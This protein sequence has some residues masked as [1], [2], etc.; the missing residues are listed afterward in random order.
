MT[1]L[2]THVEHRLTLSGKTIASWLHRL[3]EIVFAPRAPIPPEE[4]MSAQARREAA[5]AAVDRL[6]Y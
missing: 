2:N 1:F 4:F 3:S 5:R 6:L